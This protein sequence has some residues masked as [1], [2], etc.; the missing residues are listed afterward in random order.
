MLSMPRSWVSHHRRILPYPLLFVLVAC[1][2]AGAPDASGTTVLNDAAA[3][4][5]STIAADAPSGAF[6]AGDNG[7]DA[8]DTEGDSGPVS[9]SDA[10]VDWQHWNYTLNPDNTIQDYSNGPRSIVDQ[11]FAAIVLENDWVKVTLIPGYGARIFSIV[12]KPTGHEELY[13]NP[14][15][16]PYGYMEGDFYY[17]WLMVFGGI[18]PTLIEPEHGKAW[19]LPWSEQVTEQTSDHISVQMSITDNIQATSATPAKFNYGTTGLELTATVTLYR[20]RSSVDMALQLT[21]PGQ[22]DVNYE[23]WTCTTL[24]PGSQPGSPSAPGN[25]EIIA[26]VSQVQPTLGDWLGTQILPWNQSLSLFSNWQNQGILYAYPSMA[27]P[28]WGAI[29]H[30]AHEGMFRIADNADETP[31]M[32][33]WTWGYTQSQIDPTAVANA[34]N[35]SRPYIELW[36]G[37]SHEFFTPVTIAAGATHQWTESFL[38]TVG[39]DEVTSASADGAAYVYAQTSG[40]NVTFAADFFSAHPG[41]SVTGTLSL[42]GQAIGSSATLVADPQAPVHFSAAESAGGIAAGNHQLTFVASDG[43]AMLLTA[44]TTY[45][46]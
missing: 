10:M 43:S 13:Q 34:A 14:V 29:N 18:F 5:T 19:L 24:A 40:A 25:T 1:S 3:D 30:V 44:S 20:D 12:Y 21:N 15:G 41:S 6:D 8:A 28:F 38:P 17:N 16:A 32:K 4:A 11:T 46:Q 7:G 9:M 22:A 26:A 31:G 27:A 33:M 36:G 23:Y 42:D 37:V 39:L 45:T 35:G 2:K